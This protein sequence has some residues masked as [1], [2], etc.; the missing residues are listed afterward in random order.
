MARIVLALLLLGLAVTTAGGVAWAADGDPPSWQVT[1]TPYLW[2][3]GLT[4]DVTVGRVTASPDASF[5]DVLE[6]SD[7]L[8]GFQGHID[9]TRGPLGAFVDVYL[10]L[11]VDDAGRTRID[12]ESRMWYVEFGLRYPLPRYGRPPGAQGR[13]PR[14]L[15]RRPLLLS[16][17]RPRHAGGGVRQPEHRLGRPDRR[18]PGDLRSDRALLHPRP[19]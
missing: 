8:V 11:G 6:S 1:V 7:S 4:G 17:H 14:R 5:I 15:R 16:G 12:V 9:V 2:T 18:R 13:R 3:A 10:K 19:G